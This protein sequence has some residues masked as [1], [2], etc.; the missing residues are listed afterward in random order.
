MFTTPRAKL[1]QVNNTLGVNNIA[2]QQDT[3]RVIYDTVDAATTFGQFFTNFAG[4]T[5]FDCNI[6]SNKLDSEE[7]MVINEMIFKATE[8]IFAVPTNLNVYVGDNTVIKDFNLMYAATDGFQEFPISSNNS[9]TLVSLPMLTSIVIPPQ[10][11]FK[12]T[13]ETSFGQDFD[14]G[15][16]IALK[17]FGKIFKPNVSL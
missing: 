5:A 13:L 1:N 17:G 8:G 2:S 11:T 12:V 3:T 14:E 9:S 4:K 7:S 6:V 15:V 10:V 16:K